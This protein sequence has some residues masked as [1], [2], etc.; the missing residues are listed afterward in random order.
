MKRMEVD[1]STRT[2]IMSFKQNPYI[3]GKPVPGV[4]PGTA[5]FNATGLLLNDVCEICEMLLFRKHKKDNF[6]YVLI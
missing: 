1:L 4:E 6:V 3:S 5:C 2:F